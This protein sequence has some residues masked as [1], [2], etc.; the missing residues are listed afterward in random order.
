MHDHI[1]AYYCVMV[2][3]GDGV[4]QVSNVKEYGTIELNL[5]LNLVYGNLQS[6]V[7]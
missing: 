6:G 5:V 2:V 1:E 7:V 3:K 4:I